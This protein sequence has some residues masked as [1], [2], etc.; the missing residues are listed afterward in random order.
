MLYP[1]S[2]LSECFRSQGETLV[3]GL[4]PGEV[5]EASLFRRIDECDIF[6]LFWSSNAR[7]SEWVQQEIRHARG[8]QGPDGELPPTILP[9]IIEG[10]PPPPPPPELAHLHFND[11][12]LYLTC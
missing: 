1:R 9:V 4:E 6:L 8:R 11:Y 12:L 10:P 5:F 2:P 7:A 3:L